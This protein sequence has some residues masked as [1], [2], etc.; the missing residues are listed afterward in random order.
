MRN[1]HGPKFLPE[2]LSQTS[3]IESC[4]RLSLSRFMATPGSVQDFFP[5]SVL[6]DSSGKVWRTIW[7]CQRSQDR[8]PICCTICLP[9]P[10]RLS[11]TWQL[12]IFPQY[13]TR[14]NGF[15]STSLS[16]PQSP[17]A[18]AAM[19]ELN[20]APHKWNVDGVLIYVSQLP[21]ICE[22]E[23]PLFSSSAMQSADYLFISKYNDSSYYF[24]VLGVERTQTKQSSV[25]GP[26]VNLKYVALFSEIFLA[27]LVQPYG[28]AG[29]TK[30]STPCAILSVYLPL[31]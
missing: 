29:D 13:V 10:L 19:I 22:Q 30:A 5:G 21:K 2:L 28:S 4:V 16:K 8:H 31:R 20:N 1:I 12:C 14:A 3:N 7:G 9:T 26:Q 24:E 11:L 6:R 18:N 23:W 17:P 15:A 27:R 25:L